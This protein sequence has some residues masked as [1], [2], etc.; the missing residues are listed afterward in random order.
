MINSRL[1][2][3]IRKEFI[4]ILRDPRTLT[5]VLVIP[6]MQLFLLGYAA[7]NDIREV[8]LVVF[9]Q[10]RGPAARELLEAYRASDYFLV[11]YD[12]PT[13]QELTDLIDGG[14]ARVGLIIPPD[15]T[16]QLRSGGVG[17]VVFVIDG[18]DPT[19]AS[20]ALSSAQLVG[21]SLSTQI[22]A[23]RLASRGQAPSTTAPVDVHTQVW[24]NPDLLS[25]YYM[26]PGVIGMILFA[27][28]SILTAT[29]IVR[30]RERG[31]IEQLIVTPIRSWELVVGKMLPYVILA[32]LN[33]LEVLALGYYWFKVPIRSELWIILL[34]S[35]L[36]LMTSL[37]IGLLAS[38]FANT[39]Q[40]AMLLVW[41]TLL[42]AIFLSG[43]FFPIQ[44]MPQVLQF[45]S[46]F[47]PL[48]YY[49]T[50]IRSL[51]LKENGL[52]GLQDEIIALMIFGV[53]FMSIASLRFKK[54]LD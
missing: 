49:L 7:T 34:L 40:E 50:I 1:R 32:L 18:S 48:R 54:R 9:D 27:L 37:G 28:T 6:I 11:A 10:D 31:T 44:S 39:Q 30:E 36:F 25:T 26:I 47:L 53:A 45:I 3:I 51:M 29:A 5:L 41:M 8:P 24:Y 21:Q 13:E 15:Y 22:I 16:E 33:T 42:P 4:Q 14:E 35:S 23:E 20:T 12:V 43:F 17:Q 2:S 52:I 19:V 46:Y 38:T